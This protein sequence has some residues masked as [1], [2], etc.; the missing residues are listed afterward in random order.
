VQKGLYW[1][2]YTAQV[3]VR[4]MK[5]IKCWRLTW[6][7]HWII[8]TEVHIEELCV[9]LCFNCEFVSAVDIKTKIKCYYIPGTGIRM[10][11]WG[12]SSLDDESDTV[13]WYN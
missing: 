11:D 8:I 5:T 4:S 9:I 2:G 3:L 6:T 13:F 12:L 7:N 10:A 1:I